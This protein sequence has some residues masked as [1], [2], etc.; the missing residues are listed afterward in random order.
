MAPYQ[1]NVTFMNH[2]NLLVQKNKGTW[3]EKKK[4]KNY[5]WSVINA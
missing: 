5:Y 3:V 1:M 2:V 4:R